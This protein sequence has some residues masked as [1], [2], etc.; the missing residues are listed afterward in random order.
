LSRRG[1]L[2]RRAADTDSARET[3]DEMHVA[4]HDFC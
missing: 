2:G 3:K 4:H 1:D